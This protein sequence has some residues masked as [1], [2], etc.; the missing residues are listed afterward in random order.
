MQAPESAWDALQSRMAKLGLHEADL[1]ESFVLGS[2]KGGQKV[3]RTSS[4][5]QIK[6]LPSGLEVKCQE[7]RSQYLNRMRAR[8]RLCERV[9][10]E[11]A[12]LRR[13]RGARQAAASYHKRKPS[14]AE[15]ARRMEGKKQRSSV[16]RLR[17][18]PGME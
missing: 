9:E 7:E 17:G 12:R 14:R 15:T 2:G 10:E 6:H 11:R 18:K 1:E 8:E 3:N 13:E 16:K 4:A 5:V